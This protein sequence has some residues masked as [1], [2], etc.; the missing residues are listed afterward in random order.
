MS[1][2]PRRC[3][4]N[5]CRSSLSEAVSAHRA[6]VS[7]IGSDRRG[8]VHGTN[9]SILDAGDPVAGD[10]RGLGD[11][12]RDTNADMNV[13]DV[14]LGDAY[15]AHIATNEDAETG[16]VLHHIAGD[17]RVGLNRN[18]IA[19]EEGGFAE[20][21]VAY[22]IALDADRL[23]GRRAVGHRDTGRCPVDQIA[24]DADVF[25]ARDEKGARA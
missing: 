5:S 3:S 19:M 10:R 23:A 15:V 17:Y 24:G 8:R 14:I 20:E 7:E 22:E 21:Q 12:G 6:S 16:R 25:G 9:G 11:R 18:S 4:A 1:V 2:D 13:A